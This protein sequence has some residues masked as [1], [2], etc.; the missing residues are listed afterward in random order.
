MNSTVRVLPS[1]NFDAALGVAGAE[2]REAAVDRA[3]SDA[4]GVPGQR[5]GDADR[6]AGVGDSGAGLGRPIRRASRTAATGASG[7]CQ[8]DT[9]TAASVAYA[10][11]EVPEIFIELCLS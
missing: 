5:R 8:G 1:P 3:V 10:R 11:R 9:P 4:R 7:E 2:V 6:D